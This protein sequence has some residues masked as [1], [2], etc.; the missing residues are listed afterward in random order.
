MED[1]QWPT[2]RWDFRACGK[3]QDR[4]R[5]DAGKKQGRYREETGQIQLR[6]RPFMES[7]YDRKFTV[8][9]AQGCMGSKGAGKGKGDGR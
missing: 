1:D 4:Y 9:S 5:A 3:I 2:E 7:S 8:L 6:Y